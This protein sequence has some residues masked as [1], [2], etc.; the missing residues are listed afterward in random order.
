MTLEE[1]IFDNIFK[2]IHWWCDKKLIVK[3]IKKTLNNLPSEDTYQA[4]YQID[5][6]WLLD[7]IST[8]KR[9]LLTDMNSRVQKE[10]TAYLKKMESLLSRT[11]TK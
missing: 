2:Y 4:W 10:A 5:K 11:D 7:I 1:M 3:E 8:I 9:I 6:D